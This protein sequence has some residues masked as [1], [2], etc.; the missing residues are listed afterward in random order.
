MQRI[1]KIRG[2][3]LVLFVGAILFSARGAD[4]AVGFTISPVKMFLQ[5]KR[6]EVSQGVFQIV[7]TTDAPLPLEARLQFFGVS[8]E[9]GSIAF[10]DP[11]GIAG[12][13]NPESWISLERPFLLLNPRES[14]PA[15]YTLTVPAD[16]PYG[17]F[18]LAVVFQSKLPL[19]G[20]DVSSAQLLPAIGSLFF[21]DVLP[22]AG[23]EPPLK[24]KLRIRDFEIPAEERVEFRPFGASLAHA[25]RLDRI[26]F[27]FVERSPLTLRVRLENDGRYI[28][29][30]SGIV[31]VRGMWGGEVGRASFPEGA[32]LPG[33]ARVFTVAVEK[34]ERLGA[35]P[36]IPDFVAQSFFPG[37]YMAEVI[38]SANTPH[39]EDPDV[40]TLVF[41]AFPRAFMLSTALPLTL[42]LLGV[43][44]YRRRILSALKAFI[45]QKS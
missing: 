11:K 20:G 10:V 23:E 17:T 36:F 18:T 22:R 21:I 5:S 29:R 26:A 7:N 35:L 1:K 32:V 3:L 8:D 44:F 15:A 9:S 38:L 2:L 33:A 28:G 31:R 19:A 4:A 45:W 30:P 39:I 24:G 34:P 42:M 27:S 43:V 6:G 25:L 14:R 41:W 12:G 37:R 16:A 40:K 13:E